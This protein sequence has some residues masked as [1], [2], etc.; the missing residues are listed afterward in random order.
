MQQALTLSHRSEQLCSSID[1]AGLD[2][3]PQGWTA[4]SLNSAHVH[5]FFYG[6]S[7]CF[8]AMASPTFFLHSSS[9]AAT[10]QFRIQSRLAASLYIP[11]FHLF[12][13]LPTDL[14]PPK[15]LPSTLPGIRRCS[16]L[17]TWPAHI[18]LFK[19]VYVDRVTSLYIY[20]GHN[21]N[22][23]FLRYF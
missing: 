15:Q 8:W 6:A 19:R 7:A 3:E 16:I 17:T 4:V 23:R 18:N 13:G 10:F 22:S 1:A 20:T 21:F 9:L 2:T 11:S 14:P 5:F 12:R